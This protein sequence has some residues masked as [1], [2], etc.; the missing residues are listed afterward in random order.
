MIFQ[1]LADNPVNS[2]FLSIYDICLDTGTSR[3]FY[4]KH[5]VRTGFMLND[6]RLMQSQR[7]EYEPHLSTEPFLTKRA[8]RSKDTFQEQAKE[9][10]TQ[11][12]NTFIFNQVSPNKTV[13]QKSPL[14]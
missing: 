1:Q 6:A 12:R 3:P 4:T 2:K 14:I 5:Q 7:L 9:Y 11:V 8:L 13:F 10:N